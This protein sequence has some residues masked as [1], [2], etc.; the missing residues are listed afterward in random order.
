M[1][2]LTISNQP[3]REERIRNIKIVAGAVGVGL[4]IGLCAATQTVAAACE[5]DPLLGRCLIWDS[6]H[7]YSPFMFL[8]WEFKFSAL[9]PE[10]LS[11]A[12][13]WLYGG[14]VIGFV[15]AAAYIRHSQPL[16]THGSARWATKKEIEKAGLTNNPGVVLGI[17][18]FTH[19][20]LRDDGP[21]HIFLMA[22]TRSGK[23]ICVIIPTLL[24]WT[25]SVFVTDVKGENWEK[26]AGFRQKVMHHKCIKFAP[27]ESDGSSASWNPLA[28]IRMKTLWE[29]SDVEA[30]AGMMINPFGENKDG[31][32]WPQAGKVLLKGAILHHLYWYEKE[33]RNLP[34]ITNILS[35]LS[36]IGEALPTMATYPHISATE[37]LKDKNIFQQCYGDDYI[38]EFSPYNKAFAEIFEEDIHI[39]S[40]AELKAQLKA[41]PIRDGKDRRRAEAI[42][43]ANKAAEEAVAEANDMEAEQQSYAESVEEYTHALEEAKE[44]VEAAETEEERQEAKDK[45]LALSNALAEDEQKSEQLARQAAAL[46]EKAD[47]LQREA[48]EL[49]KRYGGEKAG[50]VIDFEDEPWCYLLVHPKVREC[51]T[52]MLDKAQAEMSGVQSTVLTALNLYQDPVV[53]MNT[54]IS[55]FRVKDLLDADQALSFYLVIPPNDL[56]TLTPLVRLLINMMFN[57]LIRDMIDEHVAGCKRQRLLLLLDE[58]AQ[59]GKLETVDQAMAVCASYGIKM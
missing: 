24:T 22:P 32:Y 4:F 27:L 17:N 36:N 26:S 47:K 39:C 12:E 52:S 58:F 21:T 23:G 48:A 46:A 18:P 14:A 7:I 59:F 51:A 2:Q 30:I 8:V 1:D 13:I 38:T 9:I 31:D 15:G 25:H 50:K 6:W 44:A 3:T 33:N 5:Y 16:I 55:D 20:L 54:S 42:A 11:E 49:E 45:V 53:Q 10:I 41:H 37:F 19:K 40:L 29:G 34:N 35:F 56:H 43:A 28:E 57:R